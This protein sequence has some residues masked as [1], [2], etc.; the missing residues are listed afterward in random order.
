M[1]A[2]LAYF[3][4]LYPPKMIFMSGSVAP[5]HIEATREARRN[6]PSLLEA[7]EKILYSKLAM[8]CSIPE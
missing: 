2:A 5:A 6:N 4:G 3:L 8:P 7:C 1:L